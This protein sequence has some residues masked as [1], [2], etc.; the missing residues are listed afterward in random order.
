[1]DAS[2]IDVSITNFYK[3]WQLFKKRKRKTIEFREFEYYVEE[4]IFELSKELLNKGYQHGGYREFEVY[5]NK[6]RLIRVAGMRDRV[7]HRLVYEYLYVIFDKTFIFDVWSSR[8]GK[9]LLGAIE[10]TQEFINKHRNY[11]FL[12]GDISRFFD[13]VSQRLLLKLLEE[14]LGSNLAMYIC[15]RIIKSF[16]NKRG[17]EIG[18]PIGNIT[19]QIFANIYLNE[20]DLFVKKELKPAFYIRYGDDF[21]IVDKEAELVTKNRELMLDFIKNKLLLQLNK[22]NDIL[23]KCRNGAKFLGVKIYPNGRKLLARNFRKIGRNL[24]SKNMASYRSLI[25]QHSPKY[26]NKFDWLILEKIENGEIS[27]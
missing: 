17:E 19:S 11:Y 9:G 24:N 18:I 27:I 4:N 14:K 5:E 13:S 1:M 21:L 10:R 7:V 16:K 15:E 8:K 22:K 20:L 26:L 6:K 25:L 12:R 2:N 23:E 3:T